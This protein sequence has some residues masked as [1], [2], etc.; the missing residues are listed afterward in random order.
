MR[1]GENESHGI[2]VLSVFVKNLSGFGKEGCKGFSVA[3]VWH[4]G[5]FSQV[6]KKKQELQTMKGEGHER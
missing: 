6:G 5:C 1:A 4:A 3:A 2:G